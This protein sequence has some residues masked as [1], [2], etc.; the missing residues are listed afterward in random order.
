MLSKLLTR[1]NGEAA[2]ETNPAVDSPAPDTTG[3]GRSVSPTPPPGSDFPQLAHDLARRMVQLLEQMAGD[4][5]AMAGVKVTTFRFL[6]PAV[7]ATGNS[8]TF[9]IDVP[10]DHW[11]VWVIGTG[12][13]NWFLN[14]GPTASA[15]DP[16]FGSST[17]VRL[18]GIVREVTV[19][20]NTGSTLAFYAA[21][22]GGNGEGF[23]LTPII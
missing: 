18:P 16:Q 14:L 12:S 20:N 11:H 15:N 6:P 4:M 9:R 7:V 21:A 23:N 2:A 10:I 3:G 13:F 5:R 22:E 19:F 1:K 8:H 17:M